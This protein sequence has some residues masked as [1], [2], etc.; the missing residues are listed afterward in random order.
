MQ[1]IGLCNESSH[2]TFRY[3]ERWIC[4]K[5]LQFGYQVMHRDIIALQ[6]GFALV[7]RPGEKTGTRILLVLN[8]PYVGGI[9]ALQCRLSE[10]EGFLCSKARQQ[11]IRCF[12][13]SVVVRRP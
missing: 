13:Q 8:P 10:A 5:W 11:L 9:D 7:P 6:T 2:K 4:D 3:T 1:R 12:L